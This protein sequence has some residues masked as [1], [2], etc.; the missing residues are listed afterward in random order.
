LDFTTD[1]QVL[2]KQHEILTKMTDEI[3]MLDQ[4]ATLTIKLQTTLPV[5]LSILR[6]L[7]TECIFMVL[8]ILDRSSHSF[9]HKPKEDVRGRKTPLPSLTSLASVKAICI[10]CTRVADNHSPTRQMR[11]EF[12]I[13]AGKNT[14]PLASLA[15][16]FSLSLTFSIIL[17]S[18]YLTWR[19]K[20]LNYSPVR[21]VSWKNLSTLLVVPILQAC[22]MLKI[23]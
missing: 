16:F 7:K 4:I 14:N 20:I 12:R 15:S 1:V 22:R 11:V 10:R 13:M 21:R 3:S 23:G 2:N 17:T 6:A 18:C 9:R 5:K 8:Q 19:V